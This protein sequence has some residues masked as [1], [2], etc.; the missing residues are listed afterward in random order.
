MTATLPPLVDVLD[1]MP[2]AVCVV[3]ADG[4][5]LFVNASFQRIFGYAPD[6]VL[7]QPIFDLVHPDDRAATTE[8][9][10]TVMAG[11]LQRHFRNRYV[12]K[13]GHNVDV[14][15]SARWLPDHGVRIG[16]GREVTELRRLERELERRANHDSL[17][18]L[19]NRDRLRIDL[20]SA[21]DHAIETDHG[22]ALLYLDLDG[23]KSVNDCCGHDTGDQ[24]LR[25][26]ANRLQRSVRLGDL[27][28]RVGGDEFVV[29]LPGCRDAAA[30]QN[31]ADA[32]RASITP[33]FSLPHGLFTLDVSIGVACFPDDGHSA[34][35]L[36]THA[37]RAMY[38]I[39]HRQSLRTEAAH[40]CA[41]AKKG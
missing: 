32:L 29:M 24:V 16:V 25:E 26:V 15:W 5:F 41:G 33:P 20:Q 30:A 17:T 22:V 21:I 9:A 34:S 8:Q 19:V 40:G 7:G 38:T 36:L 39:K 1:L 31:V 6:E 11:K 13:D 2:D 18:G 14:Q 23:F 28:A 37:D 10:E 35:A 4:R 27:L 3:D 12:H